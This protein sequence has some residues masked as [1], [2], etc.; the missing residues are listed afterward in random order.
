MGRISFVAMLFVMGLACL[1]IALSSASWGWAI[2]GI[3][4][5]SV[6]IFARRRLKEESEV[7]PETASNKFIVLAF[8]GFFVG[9]ALIVF[10]SRAQP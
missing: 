3:A 4:F 2:G 7:G 1:G 8:L 5:L 6:G 9:F 10:L